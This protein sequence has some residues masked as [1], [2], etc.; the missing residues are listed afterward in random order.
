LSVSSGAVQALQS[1]ST[2]A[3]RSSPGCGMDGLSAIGDD[4]STGCGQGVAGFVFCVG[5]REALDGSRP[6]AGEA[7]GASCRRRIAWGVKHM[8]PTVMR[9]TD[10]RF[11]KTDR[12]CVG[13]GERCAAAPGG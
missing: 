6:E 2:A 7:S 9:L 4:T 10:P 8:L 13:G 11:S 5:G 3:A 1:T 12:F